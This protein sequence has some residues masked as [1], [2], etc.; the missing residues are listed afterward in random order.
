MAQ[1]SSAADLGGASRQCRPYWAARCATVC[2]SGYLVGAAHGW[3]RLERGFVIQ[4]F[5]RL[6]FLIRPASGGLLKAKVVVDAVRNV[7]IGQCRNVM[8]EA[9]AYTLQAMVAAVL[10]RPR[11]QTTNRTHA[12]DTAGTGHSV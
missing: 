2:L 7:G 12:P 11:Q 9:G 4:L 1:S 8:A 5:A 6:F 10:R 3:L